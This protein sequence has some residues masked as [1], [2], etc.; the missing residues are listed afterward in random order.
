MGFKC[1]NCSKS[2]NK[3][4]INTQKN[5]EGFKCP[6]CRKQLVESKKTKILT[7]LIAIIPIMIIAMYVPST[8][9]RIVFIFLWGIF[10]NLQIRPV[11]ANYIIEAKK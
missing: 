1:P 9:F 8:I 2:I 11:I 3:K 10:V 5:N 4:V 7:M 6:S